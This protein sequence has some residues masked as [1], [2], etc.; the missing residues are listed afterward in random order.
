MAHHLVLEAEKASGPWVGRVRAAQWDTGIASPDR[1]RRGGMGG[2]SAVRGSRGSGRLVPRPRLL[3]LPRPSGRKGDLGGALDPRTEETGGPNVP[4]T[5]ARVT[6]RVCH[7]ELQA[8]RRSPAQRPALLPGAA[9]KKARRLPSTLP[10][11]SDPVGVSALRVSPRGLACEGPVTSRHGGQCRAL[12]T[13]SVGLESR[14]HQGGSLDTVL[15]GQRP[16][17][18]GRGGVLR[19]FLGHREGGGVAVGLQPG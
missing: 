11:P 14:G 13:L 18:D 6:Q 4:H 15:R 7:G 8:C 19:R 10:R 2:R 17:E 16:E 9:D 3:L 5:W 1:D 12:A